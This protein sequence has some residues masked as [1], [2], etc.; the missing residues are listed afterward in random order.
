MNGVGRPLSSASENSEES[1]SEDDEVT[2]NT[3]K[4]KSS[5]KCDHSSSSSSSD[6]A[7]KITT[8]GGLDKETSPGIVGN[9]DNNNGH[10][11]E[12]ESNGTVSDESLKVVNGGKISSRSPTASPTAH[13]ETLR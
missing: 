6:S 5:V 11:I 12:S 9:G 7:V 2:F 4:R 10:H 13:V 8:N 1:I 3:I